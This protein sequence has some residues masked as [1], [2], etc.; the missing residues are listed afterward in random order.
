M[1][2]TSSPGAGTHNDCVSGA[3]FVKRFENSLQV[4]GSAGRSAPTVPDR[5]LTVRLSVASSQQRWIHVSSPSWPTAYCHVLMYVA[6]HVGHYIHRR[7]DLS[8]DIDCIAA[9]V[10][11]LESE[12]SCS[13]HSR[14]PWVRDLRFPDVSTDDRWKS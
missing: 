11:I 10:C 7:S 12:F 14:G 6:P 3:T 8:S 1:R 2:D 13:P 9:M 5:F 4:S